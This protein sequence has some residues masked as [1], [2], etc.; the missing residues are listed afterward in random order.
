MASPGEKLNDISQGIL[1]PTASTQIDN[2]SVGQIYNGTLDLPQ[3]D[4]INR[5]HPVN[6]QVDTIFEGSSRFDFSSLPVDTITR[7]TTIGSTHQSALQGNT[8]NFVSGQ[9]F[10]L[11]A[12]TGSLCNEMTNPCFKPSVPDSVGARRPDFDSQFDMTAAG[13]SSLNFAG[14]LNSTMTG[15]FSSGIT[16]QREIQ[17]LVPMPVLASRPIQLASAE[18]PYRQFQTS[19]TSMSHSL[20]Q[21]LP[22]QSVGTGRTTRKRPRSSEPTQDLQLSIIRQ[23]LSK[24]TGVPEHSLEAF[25]LGPQPK[26]KRSRTSIQRR[27]R[28]DVQYAGGACVLC[29]IS[30]R[31]CSGQRPCDY[32]RR[33]WEKRVYTSTSFMWTCDVW[34]KLTDHNIFKYPLEDI[35]TPEFLATFTSLCSDLDTFLRK[36]GYYLDLMD[37]VEPPGLRTIFYQRRIGDDFWFYSYCHSILQWKAVLLLLAPENRHNL[38]IFER[39]YRVSCLSL[40]KEC[41]EAFISLQKDSALVVTALVFGENQYLRNMTPEYALADHIE[42]ALRSRLKVLC[43]QLFDWS[44]SQKSV[45]KLKN[46]ELAQNISF[47]GASSF[48]PPHYRG[49]LVHD[50]LTSRVGVLL[51]SDTTLWESLPCLLNRCNSNKSGDDALQRDHCCCG[52]MFDSLPSGLLSFF[53]QS[54]RSFADFLH[55]N[56]GFINFAGESPNFEVRDLVSKFFGPLDLEEKNR[57]KETTIWILKL[58]TALFQQALR[59]SLLRSFLVI[60]NL[61]K[62]T[63]ITLSEG[64]LMVQAEGYRQVVLLYTL[65][66]AVYIFGSF[67]SKEHWNGTKSVEEVVDI[68]DAWS[69]DAP[70][71]QEGHSYLGKKLYRLDFLRRRLATGVSLDDYNNSFQWDQGAKETR[72]A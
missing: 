69:M 58:K 51:S 43:A 32:C 25:C 20:D 70:A 63:T 19:P 1:S 50:R 45:R 36:C 31:K 13:P 11:P 5:L 60:H 33:Y 71:V 55:A 67:W 46:L 38:A 72:A 66:T 23:Q 54:A 68:F 56:D 10:V 35:S 52:W 6:D 62:F 28:K 17:D 59:R 44:P 53:G 4:P 30:K 29:F 12:S 14:S 34:T 3:L 48:L 26:Q 18:L 24:Q 42:S 2:I 41:D 21:S 57:P 40:F 61:N 37:S 7:P 22:S 64:Q 27:N 47:A 65:L 9:T 15:T 39:L 49:C 16:N 8:P